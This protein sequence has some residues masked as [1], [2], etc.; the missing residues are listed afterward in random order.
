MSTSPTTT[1]L[2][3]PAGD[4]VASRIAALRHRVDGDV[5]VPGEAGYDE[6]SLAWDRA[7]AH[8]PAVV[9][10]AENVGDVIA[11]VV[12][13][14]DLGQGLGVQASGHGVVS[15]VD[16]VLLVTSRL[17]EVVV[18]AEERTAWV[19]AG[20]TSGAVVSAAQ[21]HGL[22]PLVG[23]SPGVGMV[24]YAMGGGLGWLARRYGP[25]CDAVRSFEVVTP[26]G[27]LVRACRTENPELFRALCGGA[28][29]CGV[30]TDMEI[31]LVPVT[32][33]YAGNLYY[34]ADAAAD[35]V[36]RWSAW[37]AD[38]PA[39]LTSAVVMMNYPPLP[40]VPEELRGRSFAVVRGCWCGPLE[41]GRALLDGWR[42]ALPPAIDAW[43]EMPFADVAAISQDPVDPM[44][45]VGS[46]GWLDRVD[47]GVGT[48]VAAATFPAAGPPP[49]VFSEI[50][51]LGG[52]VAT[53]DRAHTT[54]GNRDRPFLLQMTGR[55]TDATDAV[56][57]EAHL[58]TTKA[59]LGT[60]LTDRTYL[61][62]LTGEE[63]RTC[64]AS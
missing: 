21:A 37:A 38:A 11:T 27:S 32:D 40:E 47:A 16:G 42:A 26:D 17:Q 35:V 28:G 51:H 45:F 64:A 4:D 43:G 18:D 56:A 13:A 9:V 10:V 1:T 8:R 30:V 22:A 62:F 19:A 57:I 39:E 5:F 12:F 36:A 55:P 49:L 52:A 31:A 53:G 23:S 2:T 46:G 25:A 33:V 20:S 50:R 61:N 59:A 29:A 60:A 34:P 63:R 6:A 3:V 48:V 15:P 41:D 58:R 14:A 7:I 54:M 44:P 24:G